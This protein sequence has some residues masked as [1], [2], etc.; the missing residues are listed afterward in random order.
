MGLTNVSVP[1]PAV[2][3]FPTVAIQNK[4]K[5]QVR[6]QGALAYVNSLI[7][8]MPG[9]QSHIFL[10]LGVWPTLS[11]NSA[12]FREATEARTSY[13]CDWKTIATI[14]SDVFEGN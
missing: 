7:L 14:G 3:N 2:I 12:H 11:N 8:K 5:N 6:G 10:P 1:A 9:S 13:V 4:W